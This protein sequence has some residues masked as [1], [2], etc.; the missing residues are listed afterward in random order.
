MRRVHDDLPA[1]LAAIV[2]PAPLSP[3]KVAFAWRMAVGPAIDRVSTAR[4]DAA[5]VLEVRFEDRR[6]WKE[7]ERSAPLVLERVR[8]VLGAEVVA[9]I[10]L[11]GPARRPAKAQSRPA[12]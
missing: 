10:R 9:R 3:G 11:Y 4:L 12:P 5:G 6:W 8:N 1:V 2:R 7:V